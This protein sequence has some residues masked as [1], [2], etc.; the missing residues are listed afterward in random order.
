[1]IKKTYSYCNILRYCEL[2]VESLTSRPTKAS[3]IG[4][5]DYP[6]DPRCQKVN[7]T[8]RRIVGKRKPARDDDIRGQ[9]YKT[10]REGLINACK[11]NLDYLG[12][13][14][15]RLFAVDCN[16]ER[17]VGLVFD[18]CTCLF[19][20]AQDVCPL[21]LRLQFGSEQKEILATAYARLLG[22]E[23]ASLF[24]AEW[25][26]KLSG[27]HLAASLSERGVLTAA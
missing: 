14:G 1:M 8:M 22:V 23:P 12:E 5:D 15:Y 19:P 17:F 6:K 3:F 11:A 18:C 26:I 21:D 9:H 7:E 2:M 10:R 24:D 16:V 25:R 13:N 27:Q 20:Q 4:R